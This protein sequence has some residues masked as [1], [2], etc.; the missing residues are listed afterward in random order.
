MAQAL[1]RGR[2]QLRWKPKRS[3]QAGGIEPLLRALAALAEQEEL[4][5][6]HCTT[7][8]VR[9]APQVSLPRPAWALS[10][11]VR[12]V[13]PQPQPQATLEAL[14]VSAVPMLS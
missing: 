6:Q 10:E 4:Q 14:P 8:A 2:S 12:W 7:L 13:S 1:V 11:R 5:P 9:V 3:V